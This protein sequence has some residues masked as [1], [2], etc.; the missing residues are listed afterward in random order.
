MHS[1]PRL[2]TSKLQSPMCTY[3]VAP[4]GGTVGLVSMIF[5]FFLMKWRSGQIKTSETTTVEELCELAGGRGWRVEVLTQLFFPK[6]ILHGPPFTRDDAAD[7]WIWTV[8]SA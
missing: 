2:V 6:W 1:G 8:H 5:F 3:T 4:S 7:L